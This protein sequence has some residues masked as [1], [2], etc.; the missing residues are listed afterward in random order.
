MSAKPKETTMRLHHRLLCLTLL[1]ACNSAAPLPVEEGL[2]LAGDNRT[3]LE[4]VLGHFRRANDPQ[5]L[6]AAEFLIGNMET[7]G[8]TR[9]ELTDED[10]TELGFDARRFP[11]LSSAQ[12]ELD[13]LES[14]HA[15]VEFRRTN[16]DRDLDRITS[17]YLIENIDLAF[18]A[19]RTCPWAQSLSFE[20]FKQ[21]VLPY[22]GSNEPLGRWRP[23]CVAEWADLS[24]R[25]ED[26]TDAREAGKLVR[27]DLNQWIRFS[28]LYYLH[29]TDQSYL[30]MRRSGV[31]RC[32]DIS[33]LAAYAMRANAIP[34]ATDYTPWWATRDNN[35]AWEVVLDGEGHG[36]AGLSNRPAKVY[37]K[38]FA[39][40]TDCLAAQL[41]A[42]EEIPRWLNRRN[43]IDVTDQYVETSTV[44]L[45]LADGADHRAGYLCV[46]NGGEWRAIAGALVQADG[47]LDFADMGRELCY[48][49]AWFEDDELVP[50][51]PPLLLEAD[52]SLSMLAPREDRETVLLEAAAPRTPDA[53][54][55]QTR[56]SLTLDPGAGYELFVWDEGWQTLDTPT[57]DAGSTLTREVPAG[58]LLWLVRD[59]SRRLE[60][61]FTVSDGVQRWW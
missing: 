60:R 32:E 34:V 23:D 4:F 21:Y 28:D 19:W 14:A 10:G 47:S 58:A 12:A 8:A 52:G 51:G 30:E 49:P 22:R 57:L 38:T 40:Q 33:N 50:A 53:D 16:F 17:K 41:P 55:G 43:F 7:H 9:I 24:R 45:Q 46:F 6:A 27:A 56:A 35:H 61:I 13:K 15:G 42:G 26:P 59:D 2:V 44:H 31:G 3:E 48:L 29:P 20:V 36:T 1:A 37:R 39:V 11:D 25:M 54:T 5:K 18:E